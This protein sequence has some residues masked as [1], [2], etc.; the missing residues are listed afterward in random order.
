MNYLGINKEETLPVVKQ[1]NKLLGDYHVYYQNLRNFHWNVQGKNFFELHR[2]FEELYNDARVKIDEI[3]ERILTLRFRPLSRISDYLDIADIPESNVE[4]KDVQMV[5]V[6]LENH[7]ILIEQM[8]K[9]I[10]SAAAINDEGTVDMVT[11]F[12]KDLEKKS[13]M[14]DAWTIRTQT[15]VELN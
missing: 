10:D 8:R 13:W 2:Q 1:L 15:A 11:A 4:E 6:I 12:M 9:I 3:A 14:L 7:K 5:V